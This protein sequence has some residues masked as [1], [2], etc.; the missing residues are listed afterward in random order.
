MIQRAAKCSPKTP[1]FAELDSMLSHA[2]DGSCGI[3][4]STY[5]KWVAEEQKSQAQI[6]KQQR[7][8]KEERDADDKRRQPDKK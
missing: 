1:D 6:M 3:V 5:D 4:P 2:F 8:Y 7:M